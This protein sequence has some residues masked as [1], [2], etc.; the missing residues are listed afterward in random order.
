MTDVQALP[1]EEELAKLRRSREER[2]AA[3]EAEAQRLELEEL[4]LDEELSSTGKRGK[5]YE[6][7]VT[8]FGVFGLKKPDT[9]G[10]EAWRKLTS[11]DSAD[12]TEDKIAMILR[13]YIVPEARANDFHLAT[14]ERPEVAT[15][16]AHVFRA[17]LGAKHIESKKKF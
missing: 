15:R 12:I 14:T 5:D 11:K 8:D 13:H 1:P 9:K 6:I 17:L 16:M 7:L 4:R 3:A 2:E 10:I